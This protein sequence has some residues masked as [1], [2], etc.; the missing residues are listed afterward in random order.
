MASAVLAAGVLRA[1]LPADLRAKDMSWLLA[2]FVVGVLVVLMIGDPGRIDRQATWLRVLTDVL[3]AVITI[4]NGASAVR[5]RGRHHQRD[6]LTNSAS[7]PARRRRRDLAHQ[8]DRIWL[9]VL[10]PRPRRRGGP[11][12]RSRRTC[13]H[14]PGDD[15]PGVRT[16]RLVPQVLRL[17][18]PL[19]HDIYRVQPHR[20]PRRHDRGRSSS[21]CSRQQYHS[22]LP[23]SSSPAPS[24]SSDEPTESSLVSWPTQ[25]ASLVGPRRVTQCL[26]VMPA[27][28]PGGTPWPCGR[29]RTGRGRCDRWCEGCP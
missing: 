2:V 28:P 21:R 22:L 11:C 13:V 9:V 10:G 17:P 15:E 26:D 25:R 18:A 24:T 14:I 27:A 29:S 5:L 7:H 12:A 6:A 16:G 4:A 1:T 23:C 8:C 3:V 19:L 20:R